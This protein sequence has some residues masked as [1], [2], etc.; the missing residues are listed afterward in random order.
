MTMRFMDGG[1]VMGAMLR[2]HPWTA[3]PLGASAQWPAQLKTLVGVMLNAPQP[4]FVVWGPGQCM[5]YNDT[6][7]EILVGTI[8]HWGSRFWRSGTRFVTTWSRSWRGRMPA[9]R[10]TWMTSS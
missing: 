5:L 3:T 4:M 9:S 8:R 6:Y 10:S 1:G 7:A 2:A